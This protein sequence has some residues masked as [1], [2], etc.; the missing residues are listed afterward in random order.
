MRL[1]K[2]VA[3]I[4]PA[5]SSCIDQVLNAGVDVL[6][7]NFSHGDHDFHGK[8]YESIRSVAKILKKHPAILADLQGPKLRIG[9]FVRGKEELQK[10]QMFRFDLSADLGDENRVSLPHV[11][12]INA[13]NVGSRLLIDDGK[14]QVVVKEKGSDF[15]ITEVINGGKISD[16]KGVNVP[17]VVLDIPAL[18][19]KDI[20]DLHFALKL[21]VDYVA[22][23]FVQRPEDIDCAKEII[24][25][26]AKIVVKIEKP[27]AMQSLEAIVEKSDIVMVARG[28]LG[29]EM[30]ISRLPILQ[31]DIVSVCTRLGKPVI[32]A[33][34]ML[35]S[36]IACPSPTRAEVLDIAT[37]HFMGSDATMLSAE[38]AAGEY[39]I[40]SIKMM[41]SVLSECSVDR[42]YCMPL[43]VRDDHSIVSTLFASLKSWIKQGLRLVIVRGCSYNDIVLCSQHK[44]DIP[45]IFFAQNDREARSCAVLHGV[46]AHVAYASC[47]DYYAEGIYLAQEHGM[48][49]KGEKACF[50]DLLH[51]RI[52][53]E[54]RIA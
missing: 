43:E 23:S 17:D 33:T 13:A 51:D 18:T 8:N 48:I 6:R 15:L 45:V 1:G 19:E 24:G 47:K 35:E 41:D 12:I 29:V 25:D 4:G 40:E 14:V 39:P 16:A 52:A 28:D 38:S 10:G 36:M 34:Q 30:P 11:E 50:I 26:A 22:L 32:V 3:T 44:L 31:R 5:S 7:M 54:F 20:R 37:A 2:I 49:A 27:Q 53:C 9:R 42:R 46:F 21:G